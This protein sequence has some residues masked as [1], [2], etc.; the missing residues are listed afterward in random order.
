MNLE[1]T[2]QK[3]AEKWLSAEMAYGEG[4]G[5]RRKLIGA[6]VESKMMDSQEYHDIF[7][8]AYNALDKNKFA[9]AAVKERK[10]ADRAI[11]TSKNIRAFKSGKLNNLSTGVFIIVGGYIVAKQ[12]GYDKKIEAKAKALYKQAKI[13]VKVQKAKMQGRNVEK[14][15]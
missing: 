13:E 2:A 4:A 14:I 8:Q 5:T 10:A 6:E 11:K 1:K 3:D 15:Y 7:W 12:T 9:Q